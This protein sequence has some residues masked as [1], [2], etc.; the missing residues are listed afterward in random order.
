MDSD[1]FKQAIEKSPSI[2]VITDI[3]GNF[4]YVNPKFTEVTDYTLEEVKGKKTSLMKSGELTTQYYKEMWT[5]LLQGKEWKGEFHN[6][7]KN[8]Q[9]YWVSSLI[10]S[11][12]D[13]N[14]KIDRFISVQEDITKIKIA[15]QQITELHTFQ[16]SILS[17]IPNG[18]V[19]FDKTGKVLYTNPAMEKLT[20][21]NKFE[22][23]NNNFME[24]VD[25]AGLIT[26]ILGNFKKHKSTPV[27]TEL[28]LIPKRG[29][30]FPVKII[31]SELS[32][33]E[34][35]LAVIRDL[36]IEKL[37][38]EMLEEF[39][40]LISNEIYLTVFRQSNTGPTVY[41]TDE[42][43]FSNTDKNI[44]STKIGV[45]YSTAIGQ[46]GNTSSGLFGPLPFPDSSD[47]ESLVYT[48]FLKDSQNKD[49]RAKGKS[50][51]MFVV[52]FPKKFENFYANR[53]YI[54]TILT[55]FVEKFK[56]LQTISKKELDN[57]KLSLIE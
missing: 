10:S 54:S 13:E 48:C 40:K 31:I 18:I 37:N 41:L 33:N 36:R 15:Q 22:L 26:L 56:S 1:F 44:L 21:F 3:N 52:T 6:K 57:L 42:F 47:Y 19:T 29:E 30:S 35:Y 28:N 2:V 34:R 4:V 49:P 38:E 23:H 50:Y 20:Q 45:Y 55:N 32:K 9:L 51:C 7:K 11:V 24:L 8:G 43:N 17:T 16:N 5:H 53:H 25:S 14:G 46:G 39:H 12:K 27:E